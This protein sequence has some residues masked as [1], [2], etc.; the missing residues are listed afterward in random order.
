MD[1][2][3]FH[4]T[5]IFIQQPEREYTAYH[6]PEKLQKPPLKNVELH[7]YHQCKHTG[8]RIIEGQMLRSDIFIRS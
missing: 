5:G 4:T 3:R 6:R 8:R 7:G 2:I 1:Y